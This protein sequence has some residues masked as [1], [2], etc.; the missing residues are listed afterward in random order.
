MNLALH[1]IAL[2]GATLIVVRSA[3]FRPLQKL[4]PALFQCSMCAGMWVGVA[5]GASGL[6]QSGHGRV[7]DAIVVGAAA[8]FSSVL[9]DAV[10]LNLLG[11]PNETPKDTR[12]TTPPKKDQ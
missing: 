4:W 1:L 12:A 3:I 11:D 6:V 7:L 2:V 8:S 5:A 10:L 9:A